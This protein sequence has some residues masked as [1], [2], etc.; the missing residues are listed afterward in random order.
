MFPVAAAKHI[1]N[2]M[3]KLG[4]TQASI[5]DLEETQDITVLDV[6]KSFGCKA[7]I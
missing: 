3:K 7:H 2:R 1:L 6:T 4:V 5:V